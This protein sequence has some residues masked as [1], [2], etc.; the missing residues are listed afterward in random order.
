[1]VGCKVGCKVGDAVGRRASFELHGARANSLTP[2]AQGRQ[3][4]AGALRQLEDPRRIRLGFYRNVETMG[5]RFMFN[6]CSSQTGTQSK[7]MASR[8]A[9]VPTPSRSFQRRLHRIAAGARP[10]HL[11]QPVLAL[12]QPLCTRRCTDAIA[13]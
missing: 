3:E 12:Q 4:L 7:R 11:S 2:P 9:P 13:V 8:L 10:E 5:E 1:M 6:A